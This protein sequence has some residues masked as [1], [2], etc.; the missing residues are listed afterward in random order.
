M[1]RRDF[2]YKRF[3]YFIPPSEGN[4]SEGIFFY[5]QITEKKYLVLNGWSQGLDQFPQGCKA[6]QNYMWTQR[7]TQIIIMS[8]LKCF[9][10]R[11]RMTDP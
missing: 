6:L 7:P 1:Q 8:N 2:L 9:S 10:S 5:V 11:L 3:K 4:L